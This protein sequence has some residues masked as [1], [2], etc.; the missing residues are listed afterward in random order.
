MKK[1]LVTGCNGFIGKQLIL[2]LLKHDVKI[3][4]CDIAEC[5]A[6]EIKDYIIY[7]KIDETIYKLDKIDTDFFSNIDVL[8]HFAWCGV[9][10]NDKN[11]YE[12]QF[13][14]FDI[15]YKTLLFAKFVSIQKIIIPGSTSEYSKCKEAINGNEMPTP[16]DLY[17]ATKSAIHI[18]AKQFCEKNNLDLNWLLITS[19]YGPSRNDNNLITYT[20]NSLKEDKKVETTKLEQEWDYLYIDDLIKALYLIGEKGEPNTVY[21]IGTGE[22]HPLKYYVELIA[23][24]FN[25]RELLEIGKLPYKNQFIDNSIVDINRLR[26]LGFRID[27]KFEDYIAFFK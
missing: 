10:T 6:S 21:P 27:K 4:G 16:S 24:K 25:R 1:V 17:A 20:I 11:N 9:S 13:M 26:K 18:I 23:E 12:K 7:K 19:I 2:F 14:N 15:T 8:Y 5:A 22:H 3:I